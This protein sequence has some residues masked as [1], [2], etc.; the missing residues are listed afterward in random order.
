M[1]PIQSVL[2]SHDSTETRGV[3]GEYTRVYAI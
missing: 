1:V 2:L 3:L